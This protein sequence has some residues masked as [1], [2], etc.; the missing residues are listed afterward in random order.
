[1][2]ETMNP[3]L[4]GLM[5]KCPACG[6]GSLFS[7]YLKFADRCSACG[8]DFSQADAGD[9]PAVFVIFVAGAIIVP[10]VLAI[11]LAL[12]PPLWVHLVV[13]LPLTTAL[14]LALL[15]PFKATLF[16]LQHH[17]DAHEARLDE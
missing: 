5:G 9:G 2:T 11:E 8:E 14:I 15:R 7:G 4:A 12:T 16:A 10:L 17:N 6:K 1:M 3:F 13:W